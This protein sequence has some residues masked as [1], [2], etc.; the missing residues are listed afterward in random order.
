MPCADPT[1]I[2]FSD[3]LGRCVIMV[4]L[5]FA[6]VGSVELRERMRYVETLP[7]A[8]ANAGRELYEVGCPTMTVPPLTEKNICM[9]AVNQSIGERVTIAKSSAYHSRPS[10]PTRK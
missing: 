7:G 10:Y 3:G 6:N 9:R 8:P 4:G 2:N 1:G 5:P